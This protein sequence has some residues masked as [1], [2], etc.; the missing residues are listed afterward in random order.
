MASSALRG[1]QAVGERLYVG[2]AP[3][4]FDAQVSDSHDR[5]RVNGSARWI[6]VVGRVMG[7]R[8]G[9]TSGPTWQTRR[10]FR[11]VSFL[12]WSMAFPAPL[13]RSPQL[14][15]GSARVLPLQDTQ[16]RH[17]DQLPPR[18]ASRRTTRGRATGGG[19]VIIWTVVQRDIRFIATPLASSCIRR[20][21][22]LIPTDKLQGHARHHPC[23][24][25]PSETS[26]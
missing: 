16:K 14:S 9:P 5:P 6:R 7:P 21:S 11:S 12:S 3:I 4:G 26:T 25:F 17:R 18:P 10:L 20:R 2:F 22:K 24:Q 1:K 8:N 19:V 23:A 13:S 15:T